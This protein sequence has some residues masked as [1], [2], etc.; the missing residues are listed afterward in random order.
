MT[1]SGPQKSPDLPGELRGKKQIKPGE[2]FCFGCHSGLSCYTHC[3]SDINIMLTPTDVLGLARKL[4]ITTSDFLDEYTVTPITKDLHL[5]VVVLR[6]GDDD[7]KK[8]KLL[9][10]E[11]CS[12]YEARPWS[13]RMYPVGMAIPPARAGVEPEPI[14]FLIQDEFCDGH[15]ESKE[16]TL[17]QWRE[18]QGLGDREELEKSYQEIV[19]HPWFIGGRQLDPKRMQM[20]HTA[21]FDLDGFRSFVFDSTFLKRFEVEEEVAGE[22]RT[23]D[24]ALLRFAFRWL[25]FALF[26]EPTLK[27]RGEQSGAGDTK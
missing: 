11:G 7:D 16:W 23:D 6:M 26:A 5:P 25:R 15:G 8:C 14:H 20:F 1:D 4:G 19:S 13:C 12:V 17:E 18:D 24:D 3:C 9:K 10:E 2:T 22:I 27:V 21:C